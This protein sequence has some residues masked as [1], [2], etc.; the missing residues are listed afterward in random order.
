V[1]DTSR[2]PSTTVRWR[3]LRVDGRAVEVMTAGAGD[4]LLFLHGWGLTPRAYADGIARLT[5]AGLSLIAPSM[6]G[7]GRSEPPPL[8]R[9]G[10]TEYADRIAALLD[11]LAIEHPAFVVG[12]SL[13]GGIAIKLA[14]TRPDLVR[15]LTLINPVGGTPGRRF[16]LSHGSWARW[17]A[18]ALTEL[19]P[20]DLI[21]LG[22]GLLRDLVPNLARR[23]LTVTAAGIVALWADLADE[24]SALVDSGL[25]VL[26]IWNDEDRVIAP[27]AFSSLG[28]DLTRQTVPG[29]HGWLLTDPVA[30]AEVVRNALVVHALLERRRRGVRA[31][32][33]VVLPAGTT[34]A[35][36][37]PPE[38][39][40]RARGTDGHQL[41]R[42]GRRP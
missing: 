8:R 40:H 1:S 11:T 27:G 20:R 4:P 9:I 22:P 32:G 25:P 17:A 36:L 5:K 28:G 31:P 14:S 29:R 12:H 42:A 18:A 37:F 15:S 7:F 3:R 19:S 30:F 2:G 24:A 34:L 10:M 26:F 13:G 39:R 33:A 23:P 21:R 35:D 16:G 41:P 6:P 38:R